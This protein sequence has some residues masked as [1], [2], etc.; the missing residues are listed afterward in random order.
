[1]LFNGTT[2]LSITPFSIIINNPTLSITTLSIIAEHFWTWCRLCS[3]SR[4]KHAEARYAECRVLNV[5]LNVK[6]NVMVP[7]KTIPTFACGAIAVATIRFFVRISN[8][9]IIRTGAVK[10][11]QLSVL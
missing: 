7:V 9:S 6:L 4:D 3:V 1:M 2:T 10:D 8:K 11:D 5:K